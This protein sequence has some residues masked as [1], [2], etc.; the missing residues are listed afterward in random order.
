MSYENAKIYRIV[1][2]DKF[3]YGSCITSINKRAVNHR[4]RAKTLDNKLYAYIKN[5]EWA[6]ELVE[7][8]PCN[9]HLELRRKEDEYVRQYLA[10]ENCLNER[11]ATLDVEKEKR[12]KKQWYMDNRDR[13]LERARNLYQLRHSQ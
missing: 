9:N 12:R 1:C 2:G 11:S 3:Y 10:D 4:C 6:I 5:K 7:E 8:F 13:I